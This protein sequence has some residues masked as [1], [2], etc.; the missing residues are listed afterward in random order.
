MD[1]SKIALLPTEEVHWDI[2]IIQAEELN[3]ILKEV[4]LMAAM[5]EEGNPQL[6]ITKEL[7]IE[8]LLSNQTIQPRS[9]A[10]HLNIMIKN[11]IRD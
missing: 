11:K 1:I 6:L 3:L 10:S 2:N 7:S 9:K 5:T 4:R 8:I